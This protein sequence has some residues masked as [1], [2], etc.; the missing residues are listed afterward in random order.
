M[1]FAGRL[2][3]FADWRAMYS[4]GIGGSN[5]F[6]RPAQK[7]MTFTTLLFDLDGTLI[8]SRDDL[9]SCVNLTLVEMGCVELSPETVYGFIGEGVFNLL[10][11]SI[12]A[13]RGF[14]AAED[15]TLRG[16]EIFRSI[17]MQNC[18]VETILYEGVTESLA[19]LSNYKMAVVTNKPADISARILDG[20]GISQYFTF[21]AGGDSFAERKPS[22]LPILKTLEALGA[23]AETA[24]MI[25]DS[26]VD[27]RAAKNAGIT[28]CGCLFGFRSRTE[29]ENEGADFLIGSFAELPAALKLR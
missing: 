4:N 20:L 13:S 21:V 27:I 8:D 18:L 6:L 10:E 5:Q 12:S 29:L 28:S 24:L 23:D 22:A 3:R 25:G 17:Y 15:E 7:L 2:S 16:V 1:R 26:G 14:I 11:R 19:Q 9:A